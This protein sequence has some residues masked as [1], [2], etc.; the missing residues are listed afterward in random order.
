MGHR[1]RPR[2]RRP[3]PPRDGPALRRLRTLGSWRAGSGRSEA[4]HRGPGRGRRSSRPA[5]RSPGI[6]PRK[7]VG[8]LLQPAAHDAVG[9]EP[10]EEAAE[11]FAV[12]AEVDVPV[13]ASGAPPAGAPGRGGASTPP[14][15]VGGWRTDGAASGKGVRR[16]AEDFSIP[17]QA[18]AD[19]GHPQHGN[20]SQSR[21]RVTPSPRPTIFRDIED[22]RYRHLV[23]LLY[24]DLHHLD[25]LSARLIA[26]D[27]EGEDPSVCHPRPC[28]WRRTASMIGLP[29]SPVPSETM[30][31]VLVFSS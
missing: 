29:S 22:G 28:T 8:H 7:N 12:E 11:V 26:L 1:N 6:R 10:G 16:E 20:R 31:I 21:H 9:L 27:G 14:A 2:P 25:P 23:T 3:P 4:C 13:A 19:V 15:R 24:G 30:V 18:E 5:S 17:A